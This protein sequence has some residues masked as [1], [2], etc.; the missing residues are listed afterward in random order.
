MFEL[1]IIR[2]CIAIFG[3]LAGFSYYVLTVRANQRNMKQTLETRQISLI[4]NIV[5]RS[6]GEQGFRNM[7]ELLR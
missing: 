3:V 6:M 4:D 5:T 7:F 2:D 1:S